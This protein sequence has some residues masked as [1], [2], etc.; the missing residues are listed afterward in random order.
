[1]DSTSDNADLEALVT[2][3]QQ[4]LRESK[5]KETTDTDTQKMKVSSRKAEFLK[6]MSHSEGKSDAWTDNSQC[7]DCI[8]F[9]P[10]AQLPNGKLP[11]LQYIIEFGLYNLKV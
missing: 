3:S 7:N 5:I 4:Y 9:D 6:C 1:M 2:R 10:S 11:L 8:L